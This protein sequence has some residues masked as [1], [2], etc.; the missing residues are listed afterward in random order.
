MEGAHE[1]TL[2]ESLFDLLVG[3]LDVVVHTGDGIGLG[4]LPD[5]SG[6]Q[7]ENNKTIYH[8]I[9]KKITQNR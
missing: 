5:A 6:K 2:A 3:L 9:K 1:E 7:K 4:V 8:R